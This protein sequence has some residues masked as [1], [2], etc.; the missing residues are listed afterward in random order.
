MPMPCLRAASAALFVTCAT[1]AASSPL[2]AAEISRLLFLNAG[3]ACQGATQAS[4]A[5]LRTRPLATMNEGAATANLTCVLPTGGSAD[6]IRTTALMAYVFNANNVPATVTCTLVDGYQQ[7]GGVFAN[8]VPRT[9]EIPAGGV[10]AYVFL[11][12]DAQAGLA[13]FVQPNLSCGLPPGTG[14][15]YLLQIYAE[16]IGG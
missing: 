5:N 7:G 3:N 10:G 4:I 6:S 2:H 9:F 13:Q 11:P 16:E 14:M 1:F 12:D 8:Y 15:T